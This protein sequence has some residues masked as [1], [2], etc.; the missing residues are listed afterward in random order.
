[1]RAA[2]ERREKPSAVD[3]QFGLVF[4]GFVILL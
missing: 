2:S 4:F 3:F 1:M